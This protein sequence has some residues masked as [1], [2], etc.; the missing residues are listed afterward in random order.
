MAN[1]IVRQE[2]WMPQIVEQMHIGSVAQHMLNNAVVVEAGS[3][4]I[5]GTSAITSGTYTPGTDFTLG[6]ATAA[7]TATAMPLNQTAHWAIPV[8]DVEQ[9]QTNPGVFSAF[10]RDGGA[11][12]VEDVDTYLF[13]LHDQCIAA[14]AITGASSAALDLDSVDIYEL[15]VDAGTKLTKAKAPLANRWV[16]VSP[17]AYARI[18]KDKDHF[19]RASALGDLV[20]TTSRFTTSALSTPGF[21]GQVAGL[22]LYVSDF[23]E[24]ASSNANA[25]LVYGQGQPIHFASQLGEVK[26]S[27]LPL[28]Y[29]FVLKQLLVYG[30][31]VVGA[32]AGRIG[33]IL[34]VND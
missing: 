28:Q 20:V 10:V 31:A 17:E 29:G 8:D 22:D 14:N 7:A 33:S 16:V 5:I 3:A 15:L 21:V 9:V 24:K 18:V 6:S 23:L 27:D 4:K 12:L 34:V 30:A 2:Q 13:T 19:I 26:T 11:K 1:S 25:Y 32:N